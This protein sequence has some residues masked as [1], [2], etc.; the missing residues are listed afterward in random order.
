MPVSCFVC[1]NHAI[2]SDGSHKGCHYHVLERMEFNIKRRFF[3]G[4]VSVCRK[5]IACLSM[6]VKYDADAGKAPL[7]KELSRRCAA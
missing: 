1:E 7:V 5:T 2:V 3:S 6:M 4:G